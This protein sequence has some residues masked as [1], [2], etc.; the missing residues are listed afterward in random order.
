MEYIMFVQVDI[1]PDSNALI[2]LTKSDN[3]KE[4]QPVDQSEDWGQLEISG[5]SD[6]N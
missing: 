6:D 2:K 4:K 3:S 5:I 1:A